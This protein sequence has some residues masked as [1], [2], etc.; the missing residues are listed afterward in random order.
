MTLFKVPILG[1]K[2]KREKKMPPQN[3][4]IFLK[5]KSPNLK[6][7]IKKVFW[8]F[9]GKKFSFSQFPKNGKK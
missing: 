4:L 8:A 1:D 5:T 3:P 6:F 9:K 7:P 2:G